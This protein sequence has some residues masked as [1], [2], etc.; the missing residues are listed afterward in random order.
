MP[1]SWQELGAKRFATAIAPHPPEPGG[2][3]GLRS[4]AVVEAT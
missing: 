2:V 3:E 4:T 1:G